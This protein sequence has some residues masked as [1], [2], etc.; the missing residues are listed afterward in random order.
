MSSFK[1][2][3][4]LPPLPATPS[5]K[6]SPFYLMTRG[7]LE[8]KERA[9]PLIFC[10]YF[11][12]APG[13]HRAE[14]SP[15]KHRSPFLESSEHRLNI[16]C[17]LELSLRNCMHPKK[18]RGISFFSFPFLGFEKMEIQTVGCPHLNEPHYDSTSSDLC[19]A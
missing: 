12:D 6:P 17:F 8:N 5:Q 2:L 11:R 18:Q 1:E 10:L 19:W 9:F 15:R 7:P 4:T 3:P 13:F 14:E 16:A